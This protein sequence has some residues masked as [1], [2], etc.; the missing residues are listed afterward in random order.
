[1]ISNREV[2]IKE[3]KDDVVFKSKGRE[4]SIKKNEVWVE[5][6]REKRKIIG[7]MICDKGEKGK[8]LNE[9]V[10]KEDEEKKSIKLWMMEER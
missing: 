2:R 9:I 8:D 4:L 5:S 7:G 1:M 3:N 10:M 6:F